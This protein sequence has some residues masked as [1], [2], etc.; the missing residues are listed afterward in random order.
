MTEE[1]AAAKLAENEASAAAAKLAEEEAAAAAKLAEE[2][3][4]LPRVPK[5]K[6]LSDLREQAR[7]QGVQV[8]SAAETPTPATSLRDFIVASS[9]DGKRKGLDSNVDDTVPCFRITV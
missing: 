1:A 7:A 6:E 3:V 9:K 8:D 5:K 4:E 2:A